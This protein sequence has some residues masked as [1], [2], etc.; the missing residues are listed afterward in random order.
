[1]SGCQ[2]PCTEHV[3][4]RVKT[5]KELA[6]IGQAMAT[7]V[8]AL[9]ESSIAMSECT[10]QMATQIELLTAGRIELARQDERL[11]A[12]NKRFNLHSSLICIIGTLLATNTL[13]VVLIHGEKALKFIK[14]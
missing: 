13:T 12:G 8:T 6:V 1:M 11:K 3:E 14:W 10:A 7:H 2:Q 9:K 5:E 4:L